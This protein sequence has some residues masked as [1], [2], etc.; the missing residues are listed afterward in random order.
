MELT[1]RL[2]IMLGGK[3]G[4]G[5]TLI[6][7]SAYY[8]LIQKKVKVAA[9][10]TDSENPEFYYHFQNSPNPVT[11]IDFSKFKGGVELI[12][13][14]AA[15]KPNIILMDS[16]AASSNVM[17]KRF[18]ELDIL[19]VAKE[20]GYE[21][22]LLAVIDSGHSSVES[23]KSMMDYCGDR[24]NYLVVLNGYFMEEGFDQWLNSE[25][26]KELHDRKFME[27]GFP[28]LDPSMIKILDGND[29]NSRVSFI[30]YEEQ[31]KDQ[32]GK[33]LAIRSFLNRSELQFLAAA[34]YIGLPKSAMDGKAVDEKVIDKKAGAVK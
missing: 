26:R 31:F 5:K 28:G 18:E 17:K 19:G 20:W 21:V 4:I 10:D 22:T 6:M 3:G 24:A 11:K 1:K 33:K 9:Y 32:V 15:D 25:T 8:H 13:K 14:I 12:D 7:R 29:K 30:G 34:E 16:A 2:V 23:F 27:I